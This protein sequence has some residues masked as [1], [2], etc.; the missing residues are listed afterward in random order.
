MKL[1]DE[2]EIMVGGHTILYSGEGEVWGITEGSF[3]D[4]MSNC[5][6][7]QAVCPQPFSPLT[8]SV[9][10]IDLLEAGHTKD[11]I[12]VIK[13]EFDNV[14]CGVNQTRWAPNT[15]YNGR[16]IDIT[17]FN[18]EEH[19]MP[20]FPKPWCIVTTVPRKNI[21]DKIDQVS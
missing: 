10:C 2:N 16:L 9:A 12:D 1:R 14:I 17:A 15:A 19:G 21:F 6:A 7:A 11:A 20:K 18:F 8:C 3:D 4:L 5:T 13:N